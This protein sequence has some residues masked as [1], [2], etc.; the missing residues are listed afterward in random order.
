MD[1]D[2]R[3]AGILFLNEIG[4][5]PGI[6]HMS[7]MR[8]IDH[9][10]KKG[11]QIEKFF[12]ICG[13]L[14]SPEA[15]DNPLRYKFSWSP[16]GVILASRNSALYLKNSQRIFVGPAVLFKDRF[17]YNFPGIGEMEVYP[18]RDSMSYI[19]IYGIPETKTIYR[20]TFRY[21]VGA[22]LLIS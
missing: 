22:R 21:K 15:A 4:L 9:I 13:A 20:G 17:S 19:D 1:K 10:H 7:A 18:N 14:P 2:A 12:S 8:I 16:R 6:D 11:G 3:D 5:D